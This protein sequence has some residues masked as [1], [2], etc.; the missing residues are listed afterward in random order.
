M[1][2]SVRN[3]PLGGRAT[4][5]T[6][7]KAMAEWSWT[8]DPSF[9][10]LRTALLRQGEPDRVP[11]H[12]SVDV[13]IKQQ[14]LGIDRTQVTRTRGKMQAHGRLPLDLEV[15]FWYRAGYDFVPLSASMHAKTM[16][17]DG[18]ATVVAAK[19]AA[20][21]DEYQERGWANEGQGI[22]TS[23]REFES[24]PWPDPEEYDLSPFA[25]IGQHLKP[26]MKV[27]V[28]HGKIYT[29]VWWL[30][31]FEAFCN[32][33]KQD[34]DL[35]AR[36]YDQVGSTQLR[37]LDRA[38]GF[39]C[40]GAVRFAD[41]IAYAESLM[42][43]PKHLR[44]HFFPWLKAC[45]DLAH[46]KGKL[47]IYHTD[48]D[49]SLV[50]DEIIA[51][52]ADGLHPIEPKA[53]DI[54]KLKQTIGHRIALLGNIDLGYTL[55][56]GTPAEVEAEVKERLRTVAPGGGYALGTSNS[57]PEYVPLEN[58]NPMRAACLKYGRYPINLC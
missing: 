3:V 13:L 52:G 37:I 5:E 28:D 50:L 55:T 35:I 14:F 40:V 54:A 45:I 18:A 9:D 31:G 6:E 53:M 39:D 20:F 24:F 21:G 46:R 33:M 16:E 47:F 11:L 12:D 57:V 49:V 26:G 32:A 8:P 27:L 7:E 36:M 22:I 58:Y 19:Y 38:T 44:Q 10:R 30:M 25:G 51:A 23:M 56:R 42:V 17:L 29:G 43:S 34:P 2:A 15:E 4:R 41:D 48:G 1:D